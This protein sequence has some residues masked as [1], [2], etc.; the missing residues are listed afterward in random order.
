MLLHRAHVRILRRLLLHLRELVT[1]RQRPGGA[2]PQ[3]HQHPQRL[4][5]L[6]D[7]V[8]RHQ[9]VVSVG[10]GVDLCLVHG[11]VSDLPVVHHGCPAVPLLPDHPWLPADS[12]PLHLGQ[13]RRVSLHQGLEHPSLHRVCDRRGAQFLRLLEQHGRRRTHWCH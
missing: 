3:I 10:L 4:L 7:R 5:H 1:S 9:P 12:G 6:R 8:L 11:V 13:S 2:F